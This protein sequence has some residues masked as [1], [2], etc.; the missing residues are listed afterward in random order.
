MAIRTDSGI[1]SR[2]AGTGGG[3]GGVTSVAISMPGFFA[4]AGSP[5]TTSGTFT[6]T[7]LS[8]TGNKFLASPDGATGVPV[9]RGLVSGDI[10]TVLTIGGNNVVDWGNGVLSWPPGTASVDWN[11]QLL[12]S[13]GQIAIDWKNHLL[14]SYAVGNTVDWE[15]QNLIHGINILQWGAIF[16]WI[17]INGNIR[18]TGSELS[19]PSMPTSDPMTG[20]NELWYDPITRI[21]KVGT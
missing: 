19:F 7:I 6:I 12:L 10:P 5:I 20:S 8:Q 13:G 17:L 4:V 1:G 2:F 16:G 3:G 9:F 14:N 18:V 11:N 21:V 15:N